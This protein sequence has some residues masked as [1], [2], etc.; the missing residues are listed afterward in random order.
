MSKQTFKTKRF[1]ASEPLFK[2]GEKAD[3]A[4]IIQKGSVKISKRGPS[5]RNI[6]IATAA[7]GGIV[8]EMAIISDC[9]RSATV[10]AQEPVE[11][12]AISRDLFEKRLENI[13]PFLHS[14][15]TTVIAR[16]RKTS[17]HTVALYERIRQNEATAPKKAQKAN[18]L[19]PATA[20][21]AESG[22]FSQVNF[23]LADPN[24]QTRNSIRSG[25]F[26]HGFREICDLSDC[27]KIEEELDKHYYDLIILD[28]AFGTTTVCELMQKIRH[29]VCGKNPFLSILVVTEHDDDDFLDSF[30]NA[31]CDDILQKPFSLQDL[32]EKINSLCHAKRSF[33]VTRNYAGPDRPHLRDENGK[34][35]P[36]F[37]PPNTLGAKVL[38]QIKDERIED[39]LKKGV[40]RFNEL[41][42]ERLLVQLAWLLDRIN[43]EKGEPFD[44]FFMLEQIETVLEDLTIR[45]E[46]SRFS[47]SK[48]ICAEMQRI[49]Q[50]LKEEDEP[51]EQQWEDMHLFY[52]QLLENMPIMDSLEH[53]NAPTSSRVN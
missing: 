24:R 50:D 25:L 48:N 46:N 42:M 52:K 13:D 32:T 5:G 10:T 12:M 36:H 30:R 3:F 39:A 33:V 43:P 18:A 35:A 40:S 1:N 22:S 7:K 6:T 8:G 38:K 41:K 45:A 17:D 47:D 31:G 19:A 29:G 51:E 20:S 2:E 53:S 23:L 16:L 44:I 14:L 4:Y 49:V 37:S 11:A 34:N 21:S 15:I 27:H 26:G 9:P 28:S